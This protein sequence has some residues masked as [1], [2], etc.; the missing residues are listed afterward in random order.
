MVELKK[1]EH[2]LIQRK[3][4]RRE[5]LARASVLGI[6]L[7]LTPALLTT[8]AHAAKPKKGGR[9]RIGYS[10]GSTNDSLD[11]ATLTTSWSFLLNWQIRNN[12]VEVDYKGNAIPELAESWEPSPDASQFVFKLR[13]GVEFHNG[14]TLDAEDV[15]YSLNHHRGEDTKSA[16]KSF[17]SPIKD[18]RSDGKHTVIFT[19][20]SSNVDFPYILSDW[21]FTISPA[22]TK[23]T[24]WDKGIGTGGYIL[25]SFEPGVRAFTKRN[26]N[27]F[28]E[29]RAHF[30]EVETLN[31]QDINARTSALTT[32]AIDFMNQCDYKT[33]PILAKRP[34][35]QVINSPSGAH[36]T[37]PMLVDKPPFDNR[38]VRL[39]LKYCIDR[40]QMIKA[41]VRG[42]GTIGNDH[43]IGPTMKYYASELPQ[44]KYDVDRARYHLKK[45]GLQGLTIQLHASSVRGFID[46]AVL[47]K[48]QAAKAGINVEVKQ[49]PADAY[50]KTTWLKAPFCFSYWNP[51]PTADMIFTKVYSEE[52][53]W[54]ESHF[55]HKRFNELLK[56]ARA[57]LDE[58]K[59]KDMYT[60]C[61]RIVHNEGGSIVFMFKDFVEAASRKVAFEN[62]ASNAPSDGLRCPERFWFA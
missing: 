20:Q 61:Q 47:F 25:D 26:P 18:I 24:E 10:T 55:R 51:S 5:F 8:P 30:D 33:A 60:E 54:N 11:P 23:G 58:T 1:L 57:E 56:S 14:K 52:A 16:G 27:Y 17:L 39:A 40:E 13:K 46:C 7:S 29:G 35:V 15:V 34:N 12:L 49:V 28:K 31:I 59:R 37:M 36:Y 53:S 19:L 48:E 50:W 22:G 21:H 9:F 43:P 42:Y 32:K 38:D 62:I 41:L 45:A 44:R 2:L 6:A 3:I 4:T